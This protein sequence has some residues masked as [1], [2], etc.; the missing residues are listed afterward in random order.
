[1]RLVAKKPTQL[2]RLA[3]ILKFLHESSFIIILSEKCR[4]IT[5]SLI[6]LRMH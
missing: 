6:K 2:Q 4:A 5:K 1:M 3:G